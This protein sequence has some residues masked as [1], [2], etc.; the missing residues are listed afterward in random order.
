MSKIETPINTLPAPAEITPDA[1]QAEGTV[2]PLVVYGE[3]T[4]LDNTITPEAIAG[5]MRELGTSA[6]AIRDAAVYVD[7]KNRLLNYG[8]HYPNWLG[9][10]RFRSVPELRDVKGDIVRISASVRGKARTEEQKKR[11]LRHE[12]EHLAQHD[13]NDRNVTAGHI[14]IVGL[15]ATGAIIGSRF[16]KGKISKAAGVAAGAVLGYET[17]YMLAPHER[18]ARKRARQAAPTA[19][20]RKR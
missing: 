10:W 5:T 2:R 13:R 18:Q 3:G 12:L 20:S 6:P 9:R 7:P 11:T 14:A 19:V 16:G 17:G 8:T 1:V 15:T 4:G